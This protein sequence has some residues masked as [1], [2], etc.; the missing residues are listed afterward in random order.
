ML[1]CCT[2]KLIKEIGLTK[3]E[4]ADSVPQD[5]TLGEWCANLF[6]FQRKKCLIFTNTRTLFTF[7]SF[8]V[9]RARIKN[10]G[11]LFCEGLGKALLDEGFDGA[12]IQRLISECRDI[13]FG[14]ANNKSILGVM[15]D[16]VLNTKW[17]VWEDGGLGKCDISR[18][19]KQHNRTPFSTNKY[20]IPI[21]ELGK[22]L[23]VNINPRADF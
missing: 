14:K 17:L 12:L 15:N 9:N 21:E 5:S 2:S 1:I 20:A 13:E 19:I 16:H 7:M 10:L 18:L 8:G 23:G 4:L 6:F 3:D 22:V 11:E